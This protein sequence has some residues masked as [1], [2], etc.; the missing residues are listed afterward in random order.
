MQNLI[1]IIAWILAVVSMF[2]IPFDKDYF[3]YLDFKTLIC[4]FVMML[5]IGAFKNLRIFT[6]IAKML[7][8]KLKNTRLLT[9]SLVMMTYVFSIFTSFI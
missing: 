3:W 1:V 5:I 4:L 6:V 9:V 2:F 7:I 8:K